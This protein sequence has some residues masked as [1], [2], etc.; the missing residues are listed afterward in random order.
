MATTAKVDLAQLVAAEADCPR[1]LAL[2]VVDALFEAMR[3]R[4][5][6]GDR[7]EIRGFGTLCVKQ[8]RARLRAR[9]PRTGKSVR[10]PARRKVQ[11]KPGQTLREGLHRPRPKG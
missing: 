5:L 11:F 7:V 9:N 2:Q 10:V 3:E 4:L 8:A 6:A 1:Y